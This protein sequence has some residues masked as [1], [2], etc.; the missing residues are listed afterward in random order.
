MKKGFTLIEIMVTLAI[1]VVV[2]V[3]TTLNLA[4]N[5][6]KR[7]LDST[8]QQVA[9]LLRQAESNSLAQNQNASWGV[10][11]DNITST[12]A[13]YE[14][15]YSF[16]ASYA[17]STKVGHYVLPSGICYATSSIA[18]GSSTDIIFN[19]LSGAPS[20]STSITLQ[21]MVGG[22]CGTATSSGASGSVS[23]SG[24][25]LIFFDDFNRS[26]L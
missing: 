26:N 23:R 15:F 22:G 11:F 7:T 9:T 6:N 5:R 1:I 13:F 21:L 16:N 18:V 17:S 12:A 3:V 10:H 8:T 24:S 20:A 25:G 19:G 4:S 2:A 14:L